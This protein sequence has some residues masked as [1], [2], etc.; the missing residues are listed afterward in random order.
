MELFVMTFGMDSDLKHVYDVQDLFQQYSVHSLGIQA[1]L[2]T[3][4]V[5]SVLV[6]LNMLI[7]MMGTTLAVVSEKEGTGWRRQQV[8]LQVQEM[9]KRKVFQWTSVTA[10]T[11]ISQAHF[12]FWGVFLCVGTNRHFFSHLHAPQDQEI[13]KPSDAKDWHCCCR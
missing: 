2:I 12:L 6:L 13:T 1:L 10:F 11:E 7:A 8:R 9:K 3:Y 4:G 5:V